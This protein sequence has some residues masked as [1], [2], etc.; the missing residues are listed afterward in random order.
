MNFND[1]K[2]VIGMITIICFLGL[3]GLSFTNACAASKPPKQNKVSVEDNLKEFLSLYNKEQDPEAFLSSLD[4]E[5][6]LQLARKMLKEPDGKIVY[7]GANILIQESYMDE[8]IPSLANLITSGRAETDLKGRFAYDWAHSEDEFLA[9]RISAKILRYFISNW[10]NYTDSERARAYRLLSA[11]L[12]LDSRSTF[13]A[14][15]AERA[16]KDN[17][18]SKLSEKQ[19]ILQ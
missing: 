3:L 6:R 10:P 5:S 13:S 12:Q 15:V 11:W 7:I 14:A 16:I 8:A 2:F 19:E 18:E 17:L 1:K 4:K 9:V